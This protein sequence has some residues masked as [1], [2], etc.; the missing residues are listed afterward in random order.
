[1][2]AGRGGD[3]EVN[4]NIRPGLARD[5]RGVLTLRTH[6]GRLTVQNRLVSDQP[7]PTS[8]L[9]ESK[10]DKYS[11]CAQSPRMQNADRMYSPPPW[12]P[13]STLTQ[14]LKY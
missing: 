9:L 5:S 13:A 4:W 10:E 2:L 12:V 14:Y 6:A 1:M 3:A 11:T 8:P 7:P